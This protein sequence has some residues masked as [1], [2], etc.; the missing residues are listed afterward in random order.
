MSISLLIINKIPVSLKK[1][2]SK[3][4]YYGNEGSRTNNNQPKIDKTNNQKTI[5]SN[6]STIQTSQS[7]I[8][9]PNDN[10]TENNTFLTAVKDVV[11]NSSLH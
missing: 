9:L 11:Q 7:N 4:Y 3:Y 5:S 1:Y 6:K 10:L 8:L 2:K